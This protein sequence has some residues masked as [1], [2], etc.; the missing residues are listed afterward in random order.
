MDH[1]TSAAECH[2]LCLGIDMDI[3][4]LWSLGSGL[5]ALGGGRKGPSQDTG[6]CLGQRCPVKANLSRVFILYLL[7]TEEES[8]WVTFSSP[9]LACPGRSSPLYLLSFSCAA[10]THGWGWVQ[11]WFKR[12]PSPEDTWAMVE[13]QGLSGIP[14]APLWPLPQVMGVNSSGGSGVGGQGLL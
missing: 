7:G 4:L 10:S 6:P 8:V 12:T 5:R 1:Y 14:K 13:A 3:G 2:Q 9:F 11:A